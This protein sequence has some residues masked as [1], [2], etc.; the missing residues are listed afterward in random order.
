VE[1]ININYINTENFN[2]F[3]EIENQFLECNQGNFKKIE[4]FKEHYTYLMY[5]LISV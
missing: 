5:L 2:F 4:K 3:K 1:Y